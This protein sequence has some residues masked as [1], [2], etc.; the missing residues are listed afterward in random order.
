M[1][2]HHQNSPPK[3]SS[4]DAQKVEES[5]F[6]EQVSPQSSQNVPVAAESKIMWIISNSQSHGST[7]NCFLGDMLRR[8]C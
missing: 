7:R 4:I 8:G 1:A 6:V 2:S 5:S 3:I